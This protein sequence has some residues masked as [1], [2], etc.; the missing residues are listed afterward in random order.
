MPSLS[1][2][3][4]LRLRCQSNSKAIHLAIIPQRCFKPIFL[5][6]LSLLQ[7]SLHQAIHHL[8]NNLLLFNYLLSFIFSFKYLYLKQILFAFL[9]SLYQ[10]FKSILSTSSYS[11]IAIAY[12]LSLSVPHST[13]TFALRASPLFYVFLPRF[14]DFEISKNSKK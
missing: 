5:P 12:P 9:F 11:L 7:S 13:G 2:S 3:L 4:G 14:R 6:S 8:H 1:L 10:F